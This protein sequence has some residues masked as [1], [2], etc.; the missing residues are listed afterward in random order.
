MNLTEIFVAVIYIISGGGLLGLLK[1]VN[2]VKSKIYREHNACLEKNIDME[3][4]IMQLEGRNDTVFPSWRKDAQRRWIS[5]NGAFS[6]FVLNPYQKTFEDIRGLT[7]QEISF[8]SPELRSTLDRMD[9]QVGMKG[10]FACA[11]DVRFH[12]KAP[13][14]SIF[15][16]ISTT[17]GSDMAYFLGVAC[18]QY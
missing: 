17:E 12:E 13:L 15:K 1:H 4:R 14:F 3:R 7:N 11:T 9:D 5:A 2:S 6:K 18:P 16:T 10:G 8:F